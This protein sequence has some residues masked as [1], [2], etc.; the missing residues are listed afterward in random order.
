MVV[1]LWLSLRMDL[2]I[3]GGIYTH[4]FFYILSYECHFYNN[5]DI[6]LCFIVTSMRYAVIYRII[7]FSL[8][9]NPL[10]RLKKNLCKPSS[11]RFTEVRYLPS[12]N[13]VLM[14]DLFYATFL[15]AMLL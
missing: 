14:V 3:I 15:L 7:Y 4:V 8:E 11:L 2:K 10:I 5:I 6:F 13:C 12:F 9:Y 1:R